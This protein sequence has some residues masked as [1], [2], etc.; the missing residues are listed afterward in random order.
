MVCGHG[1]HQPYKFIRFGAMVSICSVPGTPLAA[2][3]LPL[4][5]CFG[6]VPTVKSPLILVA[7]LEFPLRNTSLAILVAGLPRSRRRCPSTARFA[8]SPPTH[9]TQDVL[10]C[11]SGC[12]APGRRQ[13]AERSV[14]EVSTQA[15]ARTQRWQQREQVRHGGTGG[16]HFDFCPVHIRQQPRSASRTPRGLRY[17]P[18]CTQ[19]FHRQG[20][21]DR[22]KVPHDNSDAAPL[23]ARPAP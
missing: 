22:R 10:R 1:C 8:R 12:F 20:S 5:G 2:R 15:A 9:D 19:G 21:V 7:N 16:S 13:T 11:T 23:E 3:V 6:I 18:S 4:T 14:C 17:G